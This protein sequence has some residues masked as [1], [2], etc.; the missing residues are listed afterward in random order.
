MDD[1][2][3]ETCKHQAQGG[4]GID[5]GTAPTRRVNL[6]YLIMK[7]RQFEHTVDPSQ[8]MIVGNKI[9]KRPAEEE[10]Q[11]LARPTLQHP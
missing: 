6:S 2:E 3:K 8:H 5:G 10:F 11:L 1:A 7:P 4:L 9:A